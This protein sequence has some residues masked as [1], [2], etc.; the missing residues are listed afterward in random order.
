MQDKLEIVKSIQRQGQ[1]ADIPVLTGDRRVQTERASPGQVA[2]MTGDGAAWQRDSQ[3]KLWV[4]QN[5]SFRGQRCPRSQPS[6]HRSGHGNPRDRGGQRRFRHD[7]G[8]AREVSR[9]KNRTSRLP[10]FF[11]L[12]C[13]AGM[14]WM[15]W[16]VGGLLLPRILTDDNFC[17]IVAAACI[18]G[19]LGWS[20]NLLKALSLKL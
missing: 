8:A 5:K 10:D 11:L 6:R 16:M 12:F 9:R 2:A 19:I 18:P 20:P 17:S 4:N 14:W 1:A 15:G 13:C 7:A 3:L